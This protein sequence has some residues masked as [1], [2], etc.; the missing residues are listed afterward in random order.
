M[1]SISL[2]ELR[3]RLSEII[4]RVERGESFIITRRG[5]HV[6]KIVPA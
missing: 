1:N 5:K 2:T 6:A 4:A 3:R